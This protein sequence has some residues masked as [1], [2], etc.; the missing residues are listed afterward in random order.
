[1]NKFKKLII[2]GFF[3]IFSTAAMALSSD[4]EQPIEIEADS[5]SLDNQKGLTLYLGNVVITQGT[6]KLKAEKVTLTYD[7]KRQVEVVIAESGKSNSPPV[8]FEQVLDTK[9][10]VKA[11][12]R[13]MEYHKKKDILH[14]KKA[15]KVWKN[16]DTITGEHIMYDAKAGKIT[17]KAAKSGQKGQGRVKVTIEPPK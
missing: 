15:A 12:A 3:L 11:E 16:K 2:L 4:Q 10:R 9:E 14:L 17:A 13:L 7:D 1:M 6:L 8:Y 5:A